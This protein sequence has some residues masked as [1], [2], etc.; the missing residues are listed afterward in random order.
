MKA[1]KIFIYA[2]MSIATVSLTSCNDWLTD[3][4]PGVSKLEDYLANGKAAIEITNGVYTPCQWE[5]GNSY[6][7]EWFI[8]DIA[9]DDALKGGEGVTDGLD[10]Y[11]I[12]NFKVN[13]TNTILLDYYRAKWQGIAR[14][15]IAIHSVEN[16]E[17]DGDMSE[18][19]KA[20]L[21]GESRFMRAYYYFCLA[22]IYGGMP[23]VDFVIESNDQWGQS[24]A[25]LEDTYKFIITDL[26]EAE[27]VLW[28]KSKYAQDDLGRAT[29]G[30]AQAM[31]LKAHLYLAG[32]LTQEGN[33]SEAAEHYKAAR[34]WG[35]K[36]IDSN[37]YSL[38]P[39]YFDNFTL[40]GENGPESVFEVQYTENPEGDYGDGNDPGGHEGYTKGTFTVRLQRSRSDAVS[41]EDANGK[42]G[43]H[44]W[45]WNKPTQ[46]LYNEY[47]PNDLRRDATILNP[48]DDQIETPAQEIYCGNR[49]LNR[50]YAMYTDG[51]AGYTYHL[52]HDAR[53]PLNYKMIRYAD[54]LLMY[55]EACCET[56]DLSAAKDALNKVRAR[57][58]LPAF[59]YTATIQGATVTFADNNQT[60]LR[61][62][63]RHERRVELAMEAIRW[64]DL[65]RW[66]IAKET[67]DAYIAGETATAKAEFGE[68]IKGKNEL[69]PIPSKEIDLS[70]VEQNPGY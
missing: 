35:K 36:V 14:A 63:I 18:N 70:H 45:G 13:P 25:S 22:R 43:D 17:P 7:S 62:A 28:L 16:I 39:T 48:T 34:D 64:F 68:F 37:E 57:V 66:G 31:L 26:E 54:V 55:A 59:P 61:K 11:E 32:F 56:G 5:Y 69:F 4:A 60:D 58:S 1:S 40:A 24:R 38:C 6:Y 53:G 21:I 47:E 23:L 49:Y 10:A 20:R 41:S 29:K 12:D 65:V 2:A 19:M 15:N 27:K 50:K 67:I 42:K 30:A 9:S 51:E 46:N 8:G 33:T 44:G 3:D 52:A